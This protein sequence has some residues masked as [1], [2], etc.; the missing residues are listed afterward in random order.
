MLSSDRNI[1]RY[2]VEEFN[3]PILLRFLCYRK[4]EDD[5]NSGI[6]IDEVKENVSTILVVTEDQIQPPLFHN[7]KCHQD[8]IQVCLS[9]FVFIQSCVVERLSFKEPFRGEIFSKI[10]EY[11]KY[12]QNR[13]LGQR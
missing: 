4:I 10:D 6:A 2:K 5:R 12:A 7:V 9:H 8:K 3:H 11:V 13:L 1:F